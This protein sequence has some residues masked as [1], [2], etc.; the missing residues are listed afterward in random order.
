[1]LVKNCSESVTDKEFDFASNWFNGTH[2]PTHDSLSNDED[3]DASQFISI[4]SHSVSFSDP[5]VTMT[6]IMLLVGFPRKLVLIF[7]R[8]L[9]L[10]F[11]R[12]V[13]PVFSRK[14]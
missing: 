5:I 1:M 10:V 7:P 3:L 13:A 4:V 12:K 2:V 8:K 9:V 11:P 14:H 6:V